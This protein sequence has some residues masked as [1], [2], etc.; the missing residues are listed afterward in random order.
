[1]RQ[2]IYSLKC[3]HCDK[4]IDIYVILAEEVDV[5]LKVEST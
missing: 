3:P 2:I 1:M 4:V 5:Y